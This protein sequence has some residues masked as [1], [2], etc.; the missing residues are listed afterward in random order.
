[1]TARV[2]PGNERPNEACS[3]DQY[4]YQKIKRWSRERDAM[5]RLECQEV[6]EKRSNPGNDEQDLR[7]AMLHGPRISYLPLAQG[8]NRGGGPFKPSFGLSGPHFRCAT[9]LASDAEMRERDRPQY[10]R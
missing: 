7:H 9:I 5:R 8:S 4:L 3:S 2:A 1:V 10:G 6:R